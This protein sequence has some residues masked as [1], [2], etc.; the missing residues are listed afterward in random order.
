MRVSVRST[1]PQSPGAPLA[2]LVQARPPEA[3]QAYC[4]AAP[5]VMVTLR[6]AGD[7]VVEIADVGAVSAAWR[8][9]LVSGLTN[10]A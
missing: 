10:E 7:V 4:P 9:T 8:S 2:A 6:V 3:N 1:A 5:T